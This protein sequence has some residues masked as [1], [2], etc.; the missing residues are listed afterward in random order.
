MVVTYFDKLMEKSKNEGIAEVRVEGK[1]E[2]IAE[3]RVE[4]IAEGRV[5]SAQKLL[6]LGKLT[7]EEIAQVTGLTI[8]QIEEMAKGA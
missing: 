1:A 7:N 4:G 3:G 6:E 5:E 8:E 2:G